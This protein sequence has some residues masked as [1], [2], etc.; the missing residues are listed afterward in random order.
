M[1]RGRNILLSALALGV[2]DLALEAT[3]DVAD[4][5]KNEA[6][7]TLSHAELNAMSGGVS[8]KLAAFM[9]DKDL[10]WGSEA[11]AGWDT[12]IDVDS[13]APSA[14]TNINSEDVYSLSCVPGSHCT[15]TVLGSDSLLDVEYSSNGVSFASTRSTI[16]ALESD[17][18]GQHIA[19]AGVSPT[20]GEGVLAGN[21]YGYLLSG[22]NGSPSGWTLSD[23][24]DIDGYGSADSYSGNTYI[25]VEYAG[26]DYEAGIYNADTYAVLYD[27]E[28]VNDTIGIS[29]DENDR[30]GTSEDGDFV[31]NEDVASGSPTV[32][33]TIPNAIPVQHLSPSESPSGAGD[34]WIYINT[35]DK[36]AYYAED[37]DT[38]D[39]DGDGV[40]VSGGDC[41]DSDASR[42]PGATEVCDG[43]D[44][45][46]D[47]VIDDGGV[48]TPDG[49]S[50]SIAVYIDEDAD[51]LGFSQATTDGH[52]CEVPEGYADNDNDCDDT[53][54]GDGCE[55]S[56]TGD[57]G[58]DTGTTPVVVDENCDYYVGQEL[59]GSVVVG[60]GTEIC[61][62]DAVDGEASGRVT[63]VNAPDGATISFD[64]NTLHADAIQLEADNAT[65][66]I[67]AENGSNG[68][69][70]YSF[71]N[72]ST[73]ESMWMGID[74]DGLEDSVGGGS[75]NFT[76]GA[77]GLNSDD[78][79]FATNNNIG[80]Y[81]A[82]ADAG[83]CEEGSADTDD[84]TKQSGFMLEQNEDGSV[85]SVRVH[86]T[87]GEID[88]TVGVDSLGIPQT[89]ADDVQG[90]NEGNGVLAD[91]AEG[92][93]CG[94]A[95]DSGTQ[96]DTGRPSFTN[97]DP[98]GCGG[99]N[100]ST[101]L[102]TGLLVVA[103]M[104]G[105]IATRRRKDWLVVS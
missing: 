84:I 105:L 16:E 2:A 6:V 56:D 83:Q 26:G 104:A 44:N 99:C 68:A 89:F 71:S 15:R 72:A 78:T 103:G 60:E 20:Y 64:G 11:Q 98:E 13:M 47:D 77:A 17:F 4:D 40:S 73:D 86:S 63:I 66:S 33:L 49:I 62:A 90:G 67:S 100:G 57:T 82:N 3:G 69:V 46:C 97:P 31:L 28:F 8:G 36:R 95:V 38:V 50:G 74:V 85:G 93:D 48:K 32:L 51:G 21:S 52:A 14:G 39:N 101:N 30:L 42:Y 18:E 10:T 24:G 80:I 43:I 79:G 23:L 55:T 96:Y 1:S 54:P 61:N 75:S 35:T 76:L 22:L 9:K 94:G 29:D 92:G 65:L 91:G 19:L 25:P 88:R 53:V 59:D 45:D 102:P 27:Q 12:G 81:A 70:I 34:V 5:L 37:Q 7:Q 87:S 41:D 58:G